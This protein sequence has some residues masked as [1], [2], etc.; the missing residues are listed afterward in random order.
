MWSLSGKT[1]QYPQWTHKIQK[2]YWWNFLP[3]IVL[4]TQSKKISSYH[5]IIYQ[6]KHLKPCQ[7][8][9][10]DWDSYMVFV[11][12]T[13]KMFH[14]D[15]LFI[16]LAPSTITLQNFLFPS[17]LTVN[18]YTIENYVSFV[19]WIASLDFKQPVTM[20]SFDI[21]SLFTNVPLHETTY[22]IANKLDNFQLT[23]IGLTKGSLKKTT[24]ACSPSL[25][26]HFQWLSLYPNRRGTYRLPTRGVTMKINGLISARHNS[27]LYIT[28][29]N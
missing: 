13:N 5:Q 14:L 18:Q 27:S 25:S 10:P 3:P 20:A 29:Q 17:S 9:V 21:D 12:S 11:K 28:L 24:G 8:P 19:N 4:R 15:Q 16:L 1:I 26:V 22:I 6:R 23:K 7:L 2:N